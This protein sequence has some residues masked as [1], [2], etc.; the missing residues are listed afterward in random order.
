MNQ[1]ALPATPRG[2]RAPEWVTHAEGEA[3]DGC[4]WV[5]RRD[6][7]E[8]RLAGAVAAHGEA[9]RGGGVAG[10]QAGLVEGE[11]GWRVVAMLRV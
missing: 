10:G 6:E 9:L 3:P 11:L 8:R 2:L 5:R 4:G 1:P 7:A